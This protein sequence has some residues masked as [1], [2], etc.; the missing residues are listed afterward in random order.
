[1]IRSELA[2][3]T[4]MCMVYDDK[5]NILVQDRKNKNWP[6]ITFPG[7]H[8][9]K[10]ESFVESVTREVLEETGLTIQY[11]ELC[12]VK[13][14]QDDE[15]ARYVVLLYKTKHYTGDLQSSD[16]GEVYWIKRDDLLKYPL[17]NDF[18]KMVEVI[19][20]DHLS[21]FYYFEDEE[22]DWALKLL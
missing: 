3:F 21:E 15:G 9:E 2:V 11:P 14:F 8:V 1:M 5:G 16:E 18:E 17:A 10:E 20:S 4:T 19:E 6:G 7:G 22:G 12:G 13:Q